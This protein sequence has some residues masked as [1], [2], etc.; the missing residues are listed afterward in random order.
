M[1]GDVDRRER[2]PELIEHLDVFA[3]VHALH[4]GGHV[5]ILMVHIVGRQDLLGLGVAVA[6][7][8]VLRRLGQRLVGVE[9]RSPVRAGGQHRD[10]R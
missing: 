7:P 10:R 6:G 8:Q 3:A 5:G 9:L 1:D 4:A 2:G